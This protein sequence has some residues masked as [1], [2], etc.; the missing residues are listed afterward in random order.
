[1]NL[2]FLERIPARAFVPLAFFCAAVLSALVALWAA[3]TVERRSAVGVEAVLSDAGFNW[4]T[5]TTD[6]LKVILGGAAPSEASRFRVLS[7]AASVVDSDRLI[8]MM[9][10]VDPAALKVP[11]F[12]IEIL[13][14]GEGISLIGLVPLR[15]GHDAIVRDLT[16]I[17][18]DGS[19]TDML[20]TADHPVPEGWKAAVSFGIHALEKLS[21]AKV[22]ISARRVAVTA[23]SD[24]AA[25]KAR[26]EAD[27]RRQ[28]P[29]GLA[30]VLDISAPRPVIA[31]FTLRFLI[32]ED[33][34][35][36]DACS[37]ESEE[38]RR[39]ILAA[40]S[41]VGASGSLTCTIGLGVPSPV[42]ADAVTMAL[43][44][45][46]RIGAGSIT[47]SDAD[48]SLIAAS[49]ADPDVFDQVVG[50]LESNLPEVFS[51]HAVL[52]PKPVETNQAPAIPVFNASL[53]SE[54]KLEM[55]GRIAN[56]IAREAV[57]S[58]AQSRFG[59]DQVHSAMRLSADL[60]VGWTVRV[61]SALQ[62][63]A[64]LNSGTALVHPDIIRIEGVSGSRGSS[65]NAARILSVELGE[66]QNFALDIRY[67]E[68]LDPLLGL[69][70]DEECVSE[71]NRILSEHKI[72][73]EPGSAQITSDGRETLDKIA[74]R[75]KDCSD[76]AM[77]VG[78]HTDS[79]GREEMNL[80]LSKD[81]AQAIISAL[82]ARRVL[83]GNLNA[84]GYGETVP[85]GD[86][87]TEAGREAN[88]R[89]E[90]RLLRPD[91]SGDTGDSATGDPSEIEIKTPD[92]TTVRPKKRPKRDG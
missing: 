16:K 61:I 91:I 87:A 48:V 76:F 36:F 13:R 90:F 67:D 49:S 2:A 45:M 8:D 52:T 70:T 29:A 25:E 32:D 68:A 65:D 30:L 53:S 88:R 56:Q 82:M 63:L 84:V 83:T 58:F 64:E 75:M 51:L 46:Q 42:W 3:G 59:S 79:Q 33:G 72:N 41:K 7:T 69:P 38:S 31:P 18:G 24:S 78:G 14:N 9:S 40:A 54:G 47:F 19:V 55:G 71:I 28:A 22:S 35:R 27:L 11:D 6:G 10:I 89:I 17:A 77:E 86:N 44:A 81:R 73:F 60:P 57:E 43:A 50:D 74:E 5:V 15:P 21:R 1:M 34:A 4:A 23:I 26:I 80:S 62:A 39:R 20:E 66:G 85:I 37:A 92:T 12:T